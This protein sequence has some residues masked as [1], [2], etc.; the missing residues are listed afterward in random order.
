MNPVAETA[1]VNLFSKRIFLLG[2]ARADLASLVAL[3]YFNA[4]C[5]KKIMV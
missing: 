2:R 1:R 5:K 4:Q 3:E